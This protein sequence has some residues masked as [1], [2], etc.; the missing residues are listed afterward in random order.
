MFTHMIKHNWINYL[1]RSFQSFSKIGEV[2]T[3]T[4]KGIHAKLFKKGVRLL[5]KN[6]Q[7]SNFAQ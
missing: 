7:Q 4:V 5:Q 2:V 3:D 1:Y 6:N